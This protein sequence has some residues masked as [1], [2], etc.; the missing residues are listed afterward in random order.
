MLSSGQNERNARQNTVV[1]AVHCLSGMVLAVARMMSLTNKKLEIVW[2][3]AVVVVFKMSHL[4]LHR[5]TEENH[6]NPQ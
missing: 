1:L 4:Y 5:K 2:M 6:E 3:E